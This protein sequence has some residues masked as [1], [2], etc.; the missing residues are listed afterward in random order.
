MLRFQNKKSGFLTGQ[1]LIA[2]RFSVTLGWGN[3]AG[4]LASNNLFCP[5]PDPDDDSA[6]DP[7]RPAIDPITGAFINP[8]EAAEAP[9]SRMTDAERDQ[10][11][12]RLFVLFDR[13]SR[14]GVVQV[15]NP[16]RAAQQSG[17][18]EPLP[19]EDEDDLQNG[20]KDDEGVE[21]AEE[22]MRKY[23]ERVGRTKSTPTTTS[24]TVA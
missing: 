2:T 12:E 4:F 17:R 24:A 7:Q 6:P 20:E 22:E 9:A 19:D 10:E 8:S 5:P 21:A 3:A 18:F 14:T 11:A 15:E 23:R 13:L 16:I 1:S